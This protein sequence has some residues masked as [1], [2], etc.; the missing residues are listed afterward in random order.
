MIIETK[1]TAAENSGYDLGI[2]TWNY[3][4][5]GRLTAYI[6]DLETTSGKVAAAIICSDAESMQFHEDFARAWEEM[7]G[8]A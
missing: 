3:C 7:R 2:Y 5:N 4:K 6:P 8:Q 1:E